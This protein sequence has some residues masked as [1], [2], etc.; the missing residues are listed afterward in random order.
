MCN[1]DMWFRGC[2]GISD[3]VED[4]GDYGTGGVGQSGKEEAVVVGMGHGRSGED[5][6]GTS[7]A[8]EAIVESLLRLCR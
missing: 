8:D 4:G 6:A 7:R 2:V 1:T 5:E 3:T